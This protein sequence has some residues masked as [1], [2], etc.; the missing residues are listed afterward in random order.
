MIKAKYNVTTAIAIS[1]K[2]GSGKTTVAAMMVRLLASARSGPVL[3]VD[4]DP[5]SCLGLTLGTEPTGT[6]AQIREDVV[7]K[8][9][10]NTGVDRIRSFEY[11]I[12]Q[13]ITEADGFDLLTMGRPEGPK[14]YCSANNILREFLKKLSSQYTYV[15]VDNEAGMEHLSRRTTN[16][17]D[18]LCIVAEQ[19]PIGFVTAK[20]IAELVKQLPISVKKTGALW[21]RTQNPQIPDQIDTLGHIPFDNAVLDSSTQGKSVFDLEQNCPALLAVQKILEQ[22]LNIKKLELTENQKT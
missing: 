2:G 13:A 8:P 10:N 22:N 21:N 18:L 14:C 19:T 17:V 12:Q 3:A 9:A 4:A 16:N 15:V 7:Q 6:I 1:G 11:G 20:R 5:N